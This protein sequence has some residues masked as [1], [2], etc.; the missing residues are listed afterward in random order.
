MGPSSGR[1]VSSPS[2]RCQGVE[3]GC[4]LVQQ[5]VAHM[6]VPAEISRGKSIYYGAHPLT[7]YRVPADL[8]V[9]TVSASCTACLPHRFHIPD[10]PQIYGGSER[11]VEAHRTM[12]R[13]LD[14]QRRGSSILQN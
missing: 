2:L 8:R 7:V 11:L 3:F 5:L 9:E 14:R 13:L 6:Y 1:G 10:M 12:I 4:L